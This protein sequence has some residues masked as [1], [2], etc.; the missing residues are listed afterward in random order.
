MEGED[1]LDSTG[2]RPFRAAV[3]IITGCLI[4]FVASCYT[5]SSEVQLHSLKSLV[6]TS[7]HFNRRF[8]HNIPSSMKET[9]P[10]MIS[11]EAFEIGAM[12]SQHQVN[13]W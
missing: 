10:N 9:A 3:T 7:T 5:F 8:E 1:G 6:H 13:N 2:P 11:R 12:T 4:G